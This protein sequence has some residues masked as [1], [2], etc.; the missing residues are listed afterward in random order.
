MAKIKAVVY[1]RTKNLG[2]YESAKASVEVELEDGDT[3]NGVRR[4]AQV[5]VAQELRDVDSHYV[6]SEIKSM[7]DAGQISD[8]GLKGTLL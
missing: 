8:R 1:S 2:N 7:I 5:L 3:L 4:L 6:E